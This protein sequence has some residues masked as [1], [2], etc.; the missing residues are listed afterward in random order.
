LSNSP[1]DFGSW[2]LQNGNTLN[3]KSNNTI[4]VF[5]IIKLDNF[6][7]LISDEQKGKFI[8]DFFKTK[9]MFKNAKPL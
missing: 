5:K 4:T 2:N 1:I 8:N 3:I 9:E 7:F 6:Y